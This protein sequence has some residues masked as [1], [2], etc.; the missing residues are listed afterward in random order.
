MVR[1][2]GEPFS[3]LSMLGQYK[4][5]E[6]ARQ[7]GLKVMLDGQGGDEV[8]LGYSTVAQ[9]VIDDH[10]KHA[11]LATAFREW[12][13]LKRNASIPLLRSLLGNVFLASSM[14]VRLRNSNRIRG[15]VT[16]DLLTEARWSVAEDWF[17]NDGVMA[18]Q[19]RELT[20]Y[21]LPQLL[22]YE[23]RNSMAFGLEARVPMLAV[24]LVEMAM[25]LP[26]RWRV[27]NGWTKF[28]LR[29]A[30]RGRVPDLI[31]WSRRKRGF[32]VPQDRWLA[33]A[34]PTIRVW[35]ADL[36]RDCP[37]N[38]Q[39]VARRLEAGEGRAH[40]LSRCLSV[41]LWMRFSGVRA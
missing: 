36:P 31:L 3:S 33:A 12:L 37:I 18:L 19:L 25:R 17:R 11:R 34:L 38:G 16:P 30:M 40:W 22:R 27:R 2:M 9:R 13:A 29:M 14:L 26:V 32:E 35:L 5:M 21:V 28:A 39:E 1:A 4:L 23:D 8:F 15:L 41:A 7:E 6:R 24:D 20:K 10:L